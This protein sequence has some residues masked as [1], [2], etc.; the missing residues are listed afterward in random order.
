MS[1]TSDLFSLRTSNSR[2]AA[3]SQ[4]QCAHCESP[5]GTRYLAIHRDKWRQCGHQHPAASPRLARC[6]AVL[7][8]GMAGRRVLTSMRPFPIN[9]P[10]CPQSPLSIA[11]TS[12]RSTAFINGERFCQSKDKESRAISIQQLFTIYITRTFHCDSPREM[13]A[14]QLRHRCDS[15]GWLQPTT[16]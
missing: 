13:T 16:R 14:R 7:V 8:R 3:A 5:H 2:P 10:T 15:G 1:T 4:R 12:P 11:E 9:E 6:N